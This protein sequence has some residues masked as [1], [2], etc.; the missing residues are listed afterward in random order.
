MGQTELRLT[1]ILGSSLPASN[2]KQQQ[3]YAVWG[4]CHTSQSWYAASQEQTEAQNRVPQK[5]GT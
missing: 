2:P 5:V 1:E 4:M 3:R